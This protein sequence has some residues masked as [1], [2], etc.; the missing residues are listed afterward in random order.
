M[1]GS[2]HDIACC[3]SP[4]G[5]EAVSFVVPLQFKRVFSEKCPRGGNSPETPGNSVSLVGLASRKLAEFSWE[6]NELP[7]P[8]QTSVHAQQEADPACVQRTPAFPCSL[9]RSCILSQACALSPA[10]ARPLAFD[11]GST[12]SLQVPPMAFVPNFWLLSIF[13]PFLYSPLLM[14]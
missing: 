14:L 10:N 6:M 9:G 5:P 2:P 13:S 7:H 1:K 8:D 3:A 4:V 11:P 12:R